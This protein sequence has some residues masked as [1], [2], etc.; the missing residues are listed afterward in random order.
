MQIDQLHL[1][2]F[3]PYKGD[4]QIRLTVNGSRNVV[5]IYG[6][7]MRGKTSVLNAIR[8][9]LYGKALGR[10]LRI[11]PNVHLVNREAI[12][13]RD[14][15]MSVEL[16][17]ENAGK[18]Y[19]MKRAV[20]RQDLVDS[21]SVDEHLDESVS[22]LV[23]GVAIRADQVIDEISQVMPEDISRFFLFD[24]ELLQEYEQLVQDRNE[25]ADRI[26]QEI[27]NALGVPALL[28]AREDLGALLNRFQKQLAKQ[29]SQ[30]NRTQAQ[31]EKL[32]EFQE[33]KSAV[34][35]ELNTLRDANR[36]ITV[37]IEDLNDELDRTQRAESV[38]NEIV[39]V[40]RHIER[41]RSENSQLADERLS[42]AST[43]WIDVVAPLAEGREQELRSQR[44]DAAS[45]YREEIVSM[46]EI[47]RIKQSL[48][49]G[50]CGS[51]NQS[52]SQQVLDSFRKNLS[53][54]ER[55]VSEAE[56]S[57]PLLT[58]I[59]A[60]LTELPK[61]SSNGSSK[62]LLRI[63]KRLANTEIE[64]VRLEN[65]EADLLEQVV[66][67][68]LEKVRSNREKV[69]R[70][71][72]ELGQTRQHIQKVEENA[73][74]LE[75]KINALAKTIAAA[76]TGATAETSKRVSVTQALHDVCTNAIDILINRLRE[77]VES[78][79]TSAFKKLT[80]DQSYSGLRINDQYGLNI[81]DSHDAVVEERSSGAEQIVALALIDGLNKVA[82]KAGPVIMDTPFGRLDPRHRKNVLTYLPEMASQVIMLVHE[83]EL[84]KERDLSHISE[85]IASVFDI[86]RVSSNHSK[87][88]QA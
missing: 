20:N 83:G 11:I 71:N 70:L 29:G 85:R 39:T 78:A 35:E 40:R 77:A 43:L 72:R 65:D 53:E 42:A 73:S 5:V 36:Q 62:E 61:L 21:P 24:A 33:H 34:D 69:G 82:D 47:D 58:T 54:L 25:Q 55:S 10:H 6:D 8:W 80:T 88:V 17:F 4:Q 2:N 22:L 45:R 79:A 12:R 13:E 28:H 23:D 67:T 18:T 1:H 9:C 68:D 63:E 76:P 44:D 14:W 56:S 30:D 3:M 86:T 66:D 57:S 38:Q 31:A 48:A 7:N 37:Q 84:D 46:A 60:A 16:Q 32:E 15:A 26:R 74:S 27:E 52:L 87:I 41:L 75:S 19:L 59:E 51:C 81:L 64:M 49:T 50:V